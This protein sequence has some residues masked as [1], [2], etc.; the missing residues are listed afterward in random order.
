MASVIRVENVWKRYDQ[1][2]TIA[3]RDV[4]LEVKKGEL[5]ILRGNS[6]GGKS[7]L[8]NLLGT[9]DEPSEGSVYIL[10]H[11]VDNS[12]SDRFLADLRLRKIGFVFQTFNLIATMSALENV[13][14]PMTI[15]GVLSAQEARNRAM[16]LL[17]MVGL[18]D[19]L[20]HLVKRL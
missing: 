18:E 2:L 15:L 10:G 19:R 13:Q 8:L 7:T 6:G 1:Q 14:L 20:E 9:L 3:L 11:R 16:K 4:S 5:V 12:S 17:K